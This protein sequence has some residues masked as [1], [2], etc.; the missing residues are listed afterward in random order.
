MDPPI[1]DFVIVT[2]SL[3]GLKEAIGRVE[4]MAMAQ[5][6]LVLRTR[7]FGYDRKRLQAL[8]ALNYKIGASIPGAVSLDGK[9]FDLHYL[10]KELDDHYHFSIRRSYA[11]PGLYPVQEV[12]KAKNQKLVV[13]GYRKEDRPF[14]NKAAT[15]LNVIRGI[16]NGVFEGS[17]P[18]GSGMYEEWFEKHRVFPIVC[19]DESVGEPVGLLDLFRVDHDVMQHV[20]DLGMYVRAEYQGLGIGTL[21][22][23]AMKTLAKRL[24]L[25]KVM[26]TVFEGNI[27][28]EKLYAKAGFVECGKPGMAARRIHQ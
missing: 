26:L 25:S 19:E 4:D 10:Y 18:W 5:E 6:K 9:R 12:E 11:K 28:A 14:L 7:I 8:R 13:R 24:N 15:H 2:D 20:M 21:L 3:A 16:A 22:I 1:A 23:D 17:V 27:P